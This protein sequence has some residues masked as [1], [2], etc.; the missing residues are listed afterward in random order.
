[1]DIKFLPSGD[2]LPLPDIGGSGGVLFKTRLT[3]PSDM[4]TRFWM[5]GDG[6]Y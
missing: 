1:M 6:E 2:C 5:D 3:S 4:R